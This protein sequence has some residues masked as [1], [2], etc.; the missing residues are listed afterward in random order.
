MTHVGDLKFAT[1]W[2]YSTIEFPIILYKIREVIIFAP[3]DQFRY[4]WSTAINI[5]L[6]TIGEYSH[7]N[8]K[9]SAEFEHL[10]HQVTRVDLKEYIYRGFIFRHPVRIA[11]ALMV[12]ASYAPYNV[13]DAYKK[14]AYAFSMLSRVASRVA[15][16]SNCDVIIQTQA[17]FS[18][19]K[20]RVAKPYFI[21]TDFNHHLFNT[22][23]K[24][25]NLSHGRTLAPVSD[26][27]IALERTAYQ[28]A[29]KLFLCNNHVRQDMLN[30]YGVV[31]DKVHIV[32]TGV[33]IQNLNH[34]QR[35]TFKK[36]LLF[37]GIDHILKGGN[38]AIETFLEL[39]KHH[40]DATLTI[41]GSTIDRT[42]EGVSCLGQI[43]L[44]KLDE[45]FSNSDI[46]LQP[47]YHE[48]FG[49]A[50]LEAMTY[51]LPCIA[52]RLK[53]LEDHLRHGENSLLAERHDP[54]E[55]A[56]LVQYLFD[57]PNK[58][59]ELGE[60]GFN[61]VHSYY[62]WPLVAQRILLHVSEHNH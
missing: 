29:D 24:L 34:C 6:L 36:R 35:S 46:Y 55:L 60:N 28:N 39:R 47:S 2:P 31:P 4:E 50:F 49:I 14:T 33:N 27:A 9:L 41:V 51:K 42:I 45:V 16:K 11:T 58:M 59:R 61:L 54:Q 3:A 23:L 8:Q 30:F 43:P 62:Q 21:Y 12:G 10:G 25:G 52:V 26:R 17:L 32:G 1:T 53:S 48:A 15:L 56:A 22:G 40:P 5:L 57:R 37:V 7:V 18:I 13:W 44:E 38:L 19:D 20:K